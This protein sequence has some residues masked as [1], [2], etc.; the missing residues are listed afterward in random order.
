MKKFLVI[1]CLMS[2]VTAWADN[3]D[4][5]KYSDERHYCKAVF[6]HNPQHCDFIK[7]VNTRYY[8]KA[9]VGKNPSYCEFIKGENYKEM[10]KVVSK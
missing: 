8:C 6:R 2:S 7:F 10:C 5:I 4:R 1:L 3:C 9:V